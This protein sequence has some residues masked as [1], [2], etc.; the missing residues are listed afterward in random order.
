[1]TCRLPTPHQRHLVRS[2]GFDGSGRSLRIWPPLWY[3]GADNSRF[4]QI[5]LLGI[6][7]FR[8]G[9]G[10]SIGGAI[11]R[12]SE[13][14]WYTSIQQKPRAIDLEIARGGPSNW[15]AP[16]LTMYA[17][18]NHDPLSQHCHNWRLD[19]IGEA[20][21]RDYAAPGVTLALSGRNPERFAA[22]AA[23]CRARGAAVE[24]KLIDVTDSEAMAVG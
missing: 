18:E 9:F 1:M 4:F 19:G 24:A 13:G 23:V 12:A 10:P 11:C 6:A 7:L 8:S 20:L 15:Q 22:V 21:A 14:V 5:R 2:S 3:A 16:Q 17:A